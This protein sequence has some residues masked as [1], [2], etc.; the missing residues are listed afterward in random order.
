MEV[1]VDA[2]E[3]VCS[4]AA[5]GSMTMRQDRQTRG[6]SGRERAEGCARSGRVRHMV[7]VWME[8]P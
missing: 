8:R 1:Q 3:T 2:E 4:L 6:L 5:E 7:F